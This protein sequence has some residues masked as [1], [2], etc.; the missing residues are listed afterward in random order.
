ML[1]QFS[2]QIIP[3]VDGICFET[4]IPLEGFSLERRGQESHYHVVS[5][6]IVDRTNTG[7]ILDMFSCV[8]EFSPVKNG[9]AFKAEV[10]MSSY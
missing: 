9:I 8:V 5:S 4:P 10:G 7:Y 6:D 3:V 2:A 1:A